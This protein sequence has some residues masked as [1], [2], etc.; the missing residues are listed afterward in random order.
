M[1]N[2]SNL[3]IFTYASVLVIIVA[4]ILS[5]TAIKLKPIQN[6]N[7]EIKK[8]QDILSSIDIKSDVENAEEL[9]DKFITKSFTVNSKGEE[10]QG[11]AFNTNLKAELDKTPE[12]RKL[13]VFECNIDDGIKYIIPVL[14]KGLWGPIW[15][16][17]ALNDD[18]S[19]I[20][21]ATFAHK[22]ETPGLGAE[23][24]QKWFQEKF[25]GKKIFDEQKNFKSIAVV[26]GGASPDDIHGVDAISGGTI[27]SKA[28]EE[29]IN[30]CLENYVNYLKIKA[31]KK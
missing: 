9:Y 5:F 19:T 14:G 28:L 6:K 30:K 2:F 26:K 22:A 17:I 4:A 12:K 18:F 10:K 31:I 29:T 8:K 16:Y 1:R 11:D 25:K 13:P 27:T 21:G 24:D 20:Y 15:G 23:I 7:I 3:Y